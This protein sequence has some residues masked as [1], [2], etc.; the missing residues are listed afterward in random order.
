[1][2]TEILLRRGRA[3]YEAGDFDTAARL[4]KVALARDENCEA[5][6]TMMGDVLEAEGKWPEAVFYRGWALKEAPKNDDYARAYVHSMLMGRC[7]Q[8]VATYFKGPEHA[9][10]SSEEHCQ[11]LFARMM[12]AGAEDESVIWKRFEEEHLDLLDEPYPRLVKVMF[13]SE[14]EDLQVVE[15]KL[16]LM[17]DSDDV[18]VAQEALL[19]LVAVCERM[20]DHTGAEGALKSAQALNEFIVTPF[21]ADFYVSHGELDKASDVLESYLMRFHNPKLAILFGECLV[22]VDGGVERI[23]GQIARMAGESDEESVRAVQYLN[24]LVAFENHDLKAMNDAFFSVRSWFKSPLALLVALMADGERNDLMQME[25][26]YRELLDLP[27]FL[28]VRQRA[29]AVIQEHLQVRLEAGDA[30]GSLLRL[31]ELL[32]TE[33]GMADNVC[34][35]SMALKGKLDKN[36]LSEDEMLGT[37]ERFGRAPA[38]LRVAAEYYFHREKYEMALEMIQAIAGNVDDDGGSIVRLQCHCLTQLGRLD[39]ASALFEHLLE[40]FPTQE[41][42]LDYWRFA[43]CYGRVDDWR[44]LMMMDGMG[45]VAARLAPFCRIALELESSDEERRNVAL[46]RLASMNFA[47]DEMLFFAAK[48]FARFGRDSEAEQCLGRI[49]PA[50]ESRWRVFVEL[51]GIHARKNNI[52]LALTIALKAFEIKPMEADVQECCAVL[53][54]QCGDWRTALDVIRSS[55]FGKSACKA[56]VD[57]WIWAMESSIQYDFNG[58]RMAVARKSC[59]DLLLY[60]PANKMALEYLAKINGTFDL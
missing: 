6:C 2:W 18:A 50:F 58:G 47:D 46:D 34:V 54:K 3:A 33:G 40:R 31:A 14:G 51:A 45:G 49:S 37:V 43:C 15:G 42:V 53:L 60:D 56:T 7:F 36:I 41:N 55:E 1:M 22:L 30:P 9:S 28:D 57:V 8:M 27:P 20:G 35:A 26:D 59:Q 48:A 21:L 19:A 16:R 17:A 11:F 23:Q 5:A 39:E 12:A 32:E 29:N 10:L 38:I 44:N 13:F 4:L 24:A 52:D 25:I